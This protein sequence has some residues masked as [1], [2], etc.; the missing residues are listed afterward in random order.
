M[1]EAGE[2]G[3]P[4]TPPSLEQ[5]KGQIDTYENI[6]SEVEKFEVHMHNY[7]TMSQSY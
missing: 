6:Y 2:D 7:I 1:E 3:V 4:E 5:F